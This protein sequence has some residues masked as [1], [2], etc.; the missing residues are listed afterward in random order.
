MNN[1]SVINITNRFEKADFLIDQLQSNYGVDIGHLDLNNNNIGPK[2]IVKVVDYLLT[3]TNAN[4][5]LTYLDLSHTQL[6][7]E[8][9]MYLFSVLHRFDN[10]RVLKLGF[11]KISKEPCQILG[12]AIGRN[13][14]ELSLK[15]NQIGPDGVKYLLQAKNLYQLES[16]DLT[17]NQIGDQGFMLIC[18]QLIMSPHNHLKVLNVWGNNIG[19]QSITIMLCDTLLQRNCHLTHLDLT[20]NTFSQTA[21]EKMIEALERNKTLQELAVSGNNMKTDYTLAKRLKKYLDRNKQLESN[22]VSSANSTQTAPLSQTDATKYYFDEL[23]NLA[24]QDP[25]WHMNYI[26][27]KEQEL[28]RREENL[29]RRE[30]ALG[31]ILAKLNGVHYIENTGDRKSVV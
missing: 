13:L 18:E 10:L 27:E 16:L 30:K 7:D 22:L 8:G 28:T 1:A 24:L 26:R 29:E 17:E 25:A 6:K 4:H 20:S 23:A 14:R 21:L 2:G 12:Q 5:T 15:Y 11:N 19:D 9:C 3:R 31:Q